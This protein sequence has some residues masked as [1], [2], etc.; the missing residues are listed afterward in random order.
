MILD[1]GCG[2]KP[3]GDVNVDVFLGKK[4][5]RGKIVPKKIPNFVLADACHLPFK[6]GA[7]EKVVSYSVIEHVPNLKLFIKEMVR[8]TNG[9]IYIETPHRFA[10]VFPQ[11]TPEHCWFFTREFFQKTLKGSK[12]EL[13]LNFPK[14]KRF[15]FPYPQIS[16]K[17]SW[18]K[19]N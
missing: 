11:I 15:K 13:R 6:D 1:V 8:V 19:S 16:I 12:V 7:F 9:E 4:Y 17:V 10:N 3:R 2:T 5:Y 18:R 14:H